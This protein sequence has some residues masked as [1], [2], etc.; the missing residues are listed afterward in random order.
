VG[1]AL[2]LKKIVQDKIAKGEVKIEPA[3]NKNI[4]STTYVS[5]SRPT[6][7]TCAHLLQ[8]EPFYTN[9]KVKLIM[10]IEMYNSSS[11]F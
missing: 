9:Y 3:S 10:Y 7:Y 8:T 6:I 5:S 11:F 4:A 2:A 1:Q